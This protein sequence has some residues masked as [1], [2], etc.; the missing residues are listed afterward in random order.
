MTDTF[1]DSGDQ[2]M[3]KDK[4]RF[5]NAEFL[6]DICF[7]V[8]FRIYIYIYIYLFIYIHEVFHKIATDKCDKVIVWLNLVAKIKSKRREGI[9]M[10]RPQVR[11]FQEEETAKARH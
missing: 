2:V 4:Q 5:Y 7:S 1:L 10:K 11:A 8:Y 6:K 3:N 9:S